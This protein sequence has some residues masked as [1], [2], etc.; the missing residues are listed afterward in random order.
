MSQIAL[1][2]YLQNQVIHFGFVTESGQCIGSTRQELTNQINPTQLLQWCESLQ[3]ELNVVSF[4]QVGLVNDTTEAI[5]VSDLETQLQTTISTASPGAALATY[6]Y[7]WGHA[8]QQA[9]FVSISIRETLD[10]GLF[11]N[12]QL[13][14]G[15]H[16]QA[17]NIGDLIVHEPQQKQSLASFLSKEGIKKST[18]H[19][20]AK[21]TVASTLRTVTFQDFTVDHL[22]E[23][24][25]N[26]DEL[27]LQVVQYLGEILGLKL[28]DM[29]NYFSPQYFVLSGFSD[30]LIDLLIKYAAPKMEASLFPVFKDK[31]KVISSKSQGEHAPILQAAA[32]A[33][34]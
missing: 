1:G 11:L 27:A 3:K 34:Q 2:I 13:A 28:S 17:G 9:N 25:R 19:C 32:I 5:T 8:N 4:H 10:S 29:T 24:L 20:M 23:A 15:H 14:Q 6:E 30:Q 12:G 22:L 7:K 21:Q 26:N 16:G 18:F 33:F 31:I